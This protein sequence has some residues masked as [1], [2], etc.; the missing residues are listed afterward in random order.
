MIKDADADLLAIFLKRLK[1]SFQYLHNEQQ[2]KVIETR[3][4]E[5]SKNKHKS[6]A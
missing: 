3:E 4:L 1:Q 5:N 6:K 2:K